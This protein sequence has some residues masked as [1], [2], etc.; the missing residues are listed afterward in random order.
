MEYPRR[1][2]Q[3]FLQSPS[4]PI[5][6]YLLSGDEQ[7]QNPEEQTTIVQ[8]GDYEQGESAE[9]L[10]QQILDDQQ[11]DDPDFMYGLENEGIT[12]LYGGLF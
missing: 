6:V 7:A 10:H 4:A 9:G 8:P 1:R 5:K 3:I 11:Q 2:F 12:D